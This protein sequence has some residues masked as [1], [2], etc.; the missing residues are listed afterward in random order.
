MTS[1]TWT[2]RDRAGGNASVDAIKHGAPSMS[3]RSRMG[4]GRPKIKTLQELMT[5]KLGIFDEKST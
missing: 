4:S 2:D 3:K 1:P 5:E